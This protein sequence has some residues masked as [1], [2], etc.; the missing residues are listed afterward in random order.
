M[1]QFQKGD[2]AMGRKGGLALQA[3]LRL[4]HEQSARLADVEAALRTIY[5][6]TLSSLGTPE[7]RLTHI[8]LYAAA[9]LG[10]SEAQDANT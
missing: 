5:M 3:R 8:R 9:V 10:G 6:V 7:D 1:A 2:S 4:E